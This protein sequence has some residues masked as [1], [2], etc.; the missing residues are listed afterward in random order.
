MMLAR[1]F[2][3]SE[4]WIYQIPLQPGILP[5]SLPKTKSHLTAT[6]EDRGSVI[7]EKL[8][9]FSKFI[10]PVSCLV[11]RLDSSGRE[12]RT[13]MSKQLAVF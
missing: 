13:K 10:T 3:V 4:K 1:I 5:E 12:K 6:D 7:S 9:N 8:G 2:N 11:L